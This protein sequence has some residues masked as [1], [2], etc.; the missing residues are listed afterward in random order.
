MTER[1]RARVIEDALAYLEL[2]AGKATMAQTIAKEL[3]VDA[4]RVNNS[5]TNYARLHPHGPVER[6]ST[7][8]FRWRDGIV[9]PATDVI[10]LPTVTPSRDESFTVIKRVRDVVVLQDP[11][12]ESVWVAKKI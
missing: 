6:I 1:Q 12:D 5:L 2:K 3:G 4:A 7:G 8:L 11:M 9:V 10:S